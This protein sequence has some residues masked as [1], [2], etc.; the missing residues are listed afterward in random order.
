MHD[1]ERLLSSL[2]GDKWKRIT[3]E[4]KAGV[5]V[6]LFS[7]FSRNSVGIGEIPDL[8]KV[9]DWC[10]LSGLSIVQLLPMND[11]GNYP[12]PYNAI[13]TFALEPSYLSIKN[14]IDVPVKDF[15]EDIKKI[16]KAFPKRNLRVDYNIKSS[17]TA[18]LKKIFLKYPAVE[19]KKFKKFISE[20]EF[21]MKYYVLF[22]II[23]K[24]HEGKAWEEWN[25]K[26]KYLSPLTTE[27]LLEENQKEKL[28]YYWIQW[29]L[30]EQL[31]S[32]RKYAND[33]KVM[34]MGDIP[35]LVSR[36]SSDVWAYK[37]YFKLDLSSG[38]PP[39]MYFASGQRWG[40]P[41]YDWMNI[42]A[43]D[44]IYV[45]QRLKYAEN[46]YDM[47]RID[48]FIGL[49]RLWTIDLKLPAEYGGLYGRFDP[50]DERIWEEHG[51]SILKI[52]NDSTSMLPCAEDLGT[53]PACSQ[54]VLEE[55]GIPGIE[56][57]RWKKEWR[58]GTFDFVPPNGYRISSVSTV[59]THDS[60]FLP[61]WWKYEAGTVDEISFEMLCR[62]H[63]LD[64]PATKD[65]LFEKD[66]TGS[67]RLL[68]KKEIDSVA[69]LLKIT[70]MDYSGAHELVNLYLITC[71]EKE[72]FLKYIEF[73]NEIKKSPA[74]SFIKKSH[75]KLSSASSIFS[76]QTIMDWLYLDSDFLKNFSGP[77]YRINTPGIVN[78]TNWSIRIP[79][80][81]EELKKLSI[82][83][84]IKRINQKS[85]RS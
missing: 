39:D 21:W 38:A 69:R 60:S 66:D 51:R 11:F 85:G 73:H 76:I 58:D 82:N 20:N 84:T 34:L 27:K 50:E 55:F 22:N 28:F 74:V 67:G 70:A 63:N 52:M 80:S 78:D 46:F 71:D 57:Q 10:N 49:L 62:K 1:Y 68:W 32:A 59:S 33:N 81:L 17:K 65:L 16:K 13:S 54:K 48:H 35:F 64:I 61:Q 8:N 36:N 45:R 23:S 75:Y 56:V 41:P 24:L 43:D 15:N 47:F 83:D 31:I 9:V 72:K 37:N 2:T 29:Q 44:F 3:I 7:V 25:I 12:A 53:V 77:E 14:L 79:Y 30:Y 5:V 26:Y 19:N 42:A 18:L 6:P 4:R 40:M